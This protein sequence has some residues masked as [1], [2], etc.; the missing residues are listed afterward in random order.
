MNKTKLN[1]SVLI[2]DSESD[3]T[4]ALQ[5]VYCLSAIGKVKVYVMSSEKKNILKYS[6]HVNHFFY[7][8]FSSELEWIEYINSKVRTYNIDLIM[9]IYEYGAHRI[10][11]NLNKLEH[12][13]RLCLLPKL[14]DF[15]N[16]RNKGLLYEFMTQHSIPCPLSKVLNSRADLNTVSLDY[17][18][19]A[20]PVEGYAGGRGIK[21]LNNHSDL[22]QYYDAMSTKSQI[23][24]QK[25]IKGY[26]ISCN[27]LCDNGKILAYTFQKANNQ[28]DNLSPLISFK[29]FE[30]AQL[31]DILKSLMQKLNW[32][33][34][35]NIDVRFD[36]KDNSFKVLEINPRSWFNIDAS[37][38]AKVNFPYLYAL[39]SL[40][41]EI[42][43]SKAN[44]F[45]YYNF[46]GLFKKILKNPLIVFNYN[47]LKKQTP[48]FF[49]LGDPLPLIYKFYLR[50][51]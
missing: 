45:E 1:F 19:I 34:L 30:N 23:I 6:K 13:D 16:A 35:A 2:P 38:I 32:S 29:F 15:N 22:I 9:P 18:L 25:Y 17:P 20:K 47:F 37:A 24:A 5:V 4:L 48:L 27:V 39:K 14:K 42:N 8:A 51:S 36:E 50:K 49:A 11:K 44:T 26:D 41:L 7:N 3:T 12:K 33:G 40:N 28:N 10:L 43:P 46:K 21:V 31:Y